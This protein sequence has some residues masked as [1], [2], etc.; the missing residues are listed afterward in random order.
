MYQ[1]NFYVP[2][3]HADRVKLAMFDCG[4]GK[5]GNYDHC[6][7]QV[8]G[9]GQFRPLIGS[10]PFLG[11]TNELSTVIELKVEMICRK[12]EIIQVIEAMKNAHPYEE[13]AYHVIKCEEF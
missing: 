7:F 6:A 9:L 4:A 13:V 12:E 10:N 5:V 11:K 3:D 1:I 2:A 8:E